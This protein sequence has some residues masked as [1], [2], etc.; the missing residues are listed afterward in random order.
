MP[1]IAQCYRQTTTLCDAVIDSERGSCGTAPTS[2]RYQQVSRSQLKKTKERTA[3][4]FKTK[5]CLIP[6]PKRSVKFTRLSNTWPQRCMNVLDVT[7]YAFWTSAQ[8]DGTLRLP[9]HVFKLRF[10]CESKCA[11]SIYPLKLKPQS[12]II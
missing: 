11:S 10:H 3:V 6:S 2:G 8:D 4:E 1:R 7:C 9:L 12:N 5:F